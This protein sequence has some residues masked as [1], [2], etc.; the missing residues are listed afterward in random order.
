MN[1]LRRLWL[2]KGRSRIREDLVEA[3]W[4]LEGRGDLGARGAR[5]AEVGRGREA[6]VRSSCLQ[7]ARWAVRPFDASCCVQ[8]RAGRVRDSSARPGVRSRASLRREPRSSRRRHSHRE[9]PDS[10]ARV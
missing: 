4:E 1:R 3:I 5:R 8:S 6:G 2:P 9:G 10:I 7:L